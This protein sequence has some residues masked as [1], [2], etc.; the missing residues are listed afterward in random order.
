MLHMEGVIHDYSSI[1]RETGWKRIFALTL[2]LDLLSS[3]LL[4]KFSS[5]ILI[6]FP[7]YLFCPSQ[8]LLNV[9]KK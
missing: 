4:L 9:D 7:P 5:V 6:L 3:P 2:S 8:L 1:N